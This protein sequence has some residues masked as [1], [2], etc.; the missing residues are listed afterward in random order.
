MGVLT[1]QPPSDAPREGQFFGGS[2]VASL[3]Q[4]IQG[5]SPTTSTSISNR[6]RPGDHKDQWTN[7][8]E[9]LLSPAVQFQFEN[10]VLPPRPLAD[11]LVD[12]YWTGIHTLYPFIHK[13]TFQQ[14]YLRLWAAEPHSAPTESD[15]KRIGLGDPAS[16]PLIFYCA[17]NAMFA[18]GCQYSNPAGA[19]REAKAEVFLQRSSNLLKQIDLLDQGELSLVQTLLL[20]A[21]Y[22]QSTPYANR[23]WNTIGLACRMAQGIGLHSTDHDSQWSYDEV[24]M[25]RCIWHSCV[26]LDVSASMALGRPA[27]ISRHHGVPLPDVV[28]DESTRDPVPQVT[29]FFNLNM[30]LFYILGDILGTVYGPSRAARTE[31]GINDDISRDIEAI[32]TSLSSFCS[33]LPRALRWEKPDLRGHREQQVL[34]QTNILRARYLH[35]K[36]LLY[37]PMLTRV[38]RFCQQRASSRPSFLDRPELNPSAPSNIIQGYACKCIDAALELI[39]FLGSTDETHRPIWW[40]SVLYMFTS[41]VVL[42]LATVCSG[43]TQQFSISTLEDAWNQCLVFLE[44][45]VSNS[46]SARKCAHDLRKAYDIVRQTKDQV[47]DLRGEQQIQQMSEHPNGPPND[48]IDWAYGA[49]GTGESQGWDDSF[50]TDL[51]W[52]D[53][54]TTIPLYF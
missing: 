15:S 13:P 41:G 19:E 11:H 30:R 27:M 16:S 2:S 4:G 46:S 37:R 28:G 17:L 35:L 42:I 26:M 54:I 3:L 6:A 49:A 34:R 39:E 47:S 52:D 51:L 10:I 18:L 48:G 25:R 23:C 1:A 36:I 14:S 29:V 31:D 22:L 50:L 20:S 43:I 8:M 45:K 53:L 24:Q 12:C 33:T 21:H 38:Y 5:T 9:D 7:S 32:K 40:Y 44:E